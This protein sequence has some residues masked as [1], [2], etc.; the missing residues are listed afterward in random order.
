MTN[1]LPRIARAMALIAGIGLIAIAF[2][3]STE[4]ILRRGFR[5]GLN[6]GTEL[7]SYILAIIASWGLAYALYERAHVRI[8]AA[9]RLLPKR[10]LVRCDVLALVGLLVFAAVLAW[11]GWG[12]LHDTWRMQSRSM[13]PLALPLWIPQAM[14]VVGLVFF[15]VVA[16]VLLVQSLWFLRRGEDDKVQELIGTPSAEDEAMAE[17]ESALAAKES[18]DI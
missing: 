12:T 10:W 14:W 2:L 13:T 8:D 3:V 15:T 4:V 16:F 17:A 18:K 7:S 5:I 11:F 1:M 6:A 9:V